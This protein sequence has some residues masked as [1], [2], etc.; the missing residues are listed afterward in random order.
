MRKKNKELKKKKHNH[1]LAAFIF[2]SLSICAAAAVLIFLPRQ[3][4][5]WTKPEELLITY[6]EYV[7]NHNYEA[8]YAM[9][10]E[11]A[12]SHISREDFIKRNSAIYEGMDTQNMKITIL[13]CDK[14]RNSIKYNNSFDTLA[15]SVSFDN[16]AWFVKGDEGYKLLWKDSLILPGLASAD[17][18][19]IQTV[20]A[21]RGNIVDRNNRM[22]AG[23]G[24]ASS[25]GI[26]PGKLENRNHAVKKI[27]DLLEVKPEEIEKKLRA[28]WVKEDSLVP[29]K[30]LRNVEEIQ[31]R[32]QTSNQE[33]HQEVQKEYERQQKLL[34]IPGVM[35]S[36]TEIRKYPLGKAAAHVIGYVQNVT[37]EDLEEHRG[38]GYTAN[39][40]MGKS[41]LEHVFER[42]L[43]GED[44]CGIYIMDADGEKKEVIAQRKV[45]HGD[46]IKVTLDSELQTVL[47]E[48]FRK[49]KSCSV[50]MDPFTGEVLALVST[51][52]YDNNDFIIGIS[53]KKWTKLSKDKKKPLYNRFRQTWCPGSSFKPVT[54]AIG[55]DSGALDPEEDFGDEGRSWRKDSSWGA[56]RITTLHTYKPVILQNALIYSDNIYF[57]KAALKIGAEQM[58]KS[59]LE[60]G[61]GENLPFDIT[62]ADSRYSNTETIETEIQLADS[63]YGQ[64]QVLVNPVHLAAIYS[65]FCNRGSVIKPHI[66]QEEESRPKYWKLQAFSETTADTVLSGLK[67]VVNDPHGTGYAAHRK[68]IVLAGKTGTAEIK[69]DK[70]DTSGTELGWFAIFTA[71]KEAKR[72]F[73]LVSMVEDV[74]GR[75]G[76]GYV[77]ARD[78]EVL[79]SWLKV[80]QR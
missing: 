48:Q 77:V 8:M 65:A 74:K 58:E 27:A 46:D 71:D 50:A 2:M 54:A 31:L 11:E 75:G 1:L 17:K 28:K 36:D 59:L 10:A 7:Q 45:K 19:R 15:G 70:K 61:F 9:L 34:A 56:Y 35:I 14:E 13:S 25:V 26:V 64:G 53:T 73:L 16:E 72:P 22:L 62:M 33:V 68:D 57:A 32:S 30:I 21:K 67:K 12:A 5:T 38:E 55:L 29:I 24:K 18:V 3:E 37:A 47:Y 51:P 52:S 39:S 49:D 66:V 80:S 60:L 79:E 4:Q 44:G 6:M 43:K 76:S 23:F 42:E 78:C 20:P 63:G 40:V 41:G 69:A